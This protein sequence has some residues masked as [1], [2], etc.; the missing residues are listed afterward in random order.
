M[1]LGT[2]DTDEMAPVPQRG[3]R[4][5]RGRRRRRLR[6]LA[7][8]VAAMLVLGLPSADAFVYRGRVHP[9]VRVEG[10]QLGG[11]TLSQAV[12]ALAPLARAVAGRR[13]GFR[14]EGLELARFRGHLETG[15]RPREGVHVG[16]EDQTA[17]SAGVSG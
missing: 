1:Q 4:V 11:R 5:E 6:W 7:A 17:V 15:A 2:P 16:W 3:S 13:V 9:G 12:E 10:T 8:G 14:W